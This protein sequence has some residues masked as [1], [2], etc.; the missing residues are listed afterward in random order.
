LNI[1]SEQPFLD[2]LEKTSIL[3]SK[4]KP[5]YAVD[6]RYI[7]HR[8]ENGLVLA[9]HLLHDF[10][11]CAQ[12]PL[13]DIGVGSGGISIAFALRNIPCTG[14]DIN[15]EYL[16]LAAL[17]ARCNGVALDLKGWDGTT[18]PVPD[19]SF[20]TV[21]ITDI[22][23]HVPSPAGLASEIARVL[24]PG[25]ICFYA[26]EIRFS[27]VFLAADPHYGIPLLTLL[28]R[29]ARR[30]IVVNALKR[31]AALDD[32]YWFG[33]HRE[34]AALFKPH[35]LRCKPYYAHK[36]QD[37]ERLKGRGG[38]VSILP[39]IPGF[40]AMYMSIILSGVARKPL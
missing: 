5:H 4:N 11:E 22:L 33:S 29:W 8:L 38:L 32:Y 21:I 34:I 28:P 14:L 30:I 18:V 1:R 7:V 9:E 27:P 13:L 20:R 26:T 10:P 23:E 16:R 39:G 24:A 40:R 12:G 19:A 31:S 35:G 15:P 36:E 37:W 17:R 25:G 2:E 6:Y 3:P